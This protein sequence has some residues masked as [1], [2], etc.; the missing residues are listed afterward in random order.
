MRLKVEGG[1][2]AIPVLRRDERTAGDAM[3]LAFAQKK[4]RRIAHLNDVDPSAGTDVDNR[5]RGIADFAFP[6]DGKG[7]HDDLR[8]VDD[9]A[10]LGDET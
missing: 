10:V 5:E 1:H 8:R 7:I 3:N 2:H 9:F 4:K 6:A